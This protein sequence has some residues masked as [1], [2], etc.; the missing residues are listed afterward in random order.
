MSKFI[1]SHHLQIHFIHGLNNKIE[2]DL[3]IEKFEFAFYE[4]PIFKIQKPNNRVL[5]VY[6]LMTFWWLS[7]DFRSFIRQTLWNRNFKSESINLWSSWLIWIVLNVK[8][9]NFWQMSFIIWLNFNLLSAG[10]ESF[11]SGDL[12]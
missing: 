4:P 11:W 12:K 5:T 2:I 9:Q 7:V 10:F 1:A 8:H 3:G 6:F